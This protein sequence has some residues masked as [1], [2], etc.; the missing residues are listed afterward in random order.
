MK[1]LLFA[2]ITVACATSLQAQSLVNLSDK[3]EVILVEGG[4]FSMG[5]NDVNEVTWYK[6]NAQTTQPVGQNRANELGLYDMS[7]NASEWCYD[8]Y[9]DYT[10]DAQTN[11][12][13]MA[14]SSNHVDRGGSWYVDANWAKLSTR[15]KYDEEWCDEIRGFRVVLNQ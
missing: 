4:T 12:I 9:A 11:P 8:S 3:P 1:P 10:S 14:S 13:G 15:N 5:S 7:G 6:G 2:F